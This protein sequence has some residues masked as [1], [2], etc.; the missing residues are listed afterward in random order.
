MVIVVTCRILIKDTV[1][2]KS[3]SFS[4]FLL[5]LHDLLSF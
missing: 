4:V 1:E 3:H 2:L 5:L